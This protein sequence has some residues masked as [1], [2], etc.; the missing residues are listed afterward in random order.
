MRVEVTRR[1]ALRGIGVAVGGG[2]GRIGGGQSTPRATVATRNLYL[3]ADLFRLFVDREGSA[4]SIV[5][6]LLEQVDSSAVERRMDAIAAELA[7]ARPDVIGVQE[8]ALVRTEPESDGGFD[9]DP[10]AD[11]VRYDFLALLEGALADRG[12]A[13]DAA[14]VSENTDAEFPARVDGGRI[15]VRL[16][17]RDAV[18]VRRRTT[19][20]DRTATATYDAA[21]TVPVGDGFTLTRGYATA[22]VRVRGRELTVSTTHLE[23]ASAAVRVEQA[24]TFRD[25]LSSA[26]PVV[27][28]GDFNDGPADGGGAY[29]VLAEAFADAYSEIH[30]DS[31]G[32]AP[33]CCFPPSLRADDPE[34]ALTDR[35]DAVFARGIRPT[36]AHRTGVD[37]STR[38]EV[39]DVLLWPSDHA[40]VVATFGE[41]SGTATDRPSTE[42]GTASDSEPET[43]TPRSTDTPQP[44]TDAAP[45]PTTVSNGTGS[46]PDATEAASPTPVTPDADATASGG[47]GFGAL[48]AAAAAL[49]AGAG[50]AARSG[51]GEEES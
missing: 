18:L 19:D 40:G 25:A 45:S 7:A 2:R 5:G 9:A 23:P 31:V 28:L 30:P 33:T 20:V 35:F 29:E 21:L 50:L 3:G 6:A 42:P 13:Y 36:G 14:V 47:P 11:T 12:I 37:P 32:E 46:P 4:A 41:G 39:D 49:G 1:A 22:D 48:L 27:A 44:S 51:T 34:A 26:S 43:V 38:I 15:D 24:E 16:T 10:D 8:A 17:D